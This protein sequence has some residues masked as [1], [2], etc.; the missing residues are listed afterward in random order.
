MRMTMVRRRKGKPVAKRTPARV[1]ALRRTAEARPDESQ[2]K[3]ARRGWWIIALFFGVLGA[4]AVMAPLNGA[5]IANSVIK[6]LGN[7][8]SIQH[9]DGGIVKQ[10][11]VKENDHVNAGDALIVLDDTQARAEFEVLSQQYLV[12]RATELRLLAELNRSSELVPSADIRARTNEPELEAIWNGQIQ[13]FS[14]QSGPW[15]SAG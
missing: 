7:R 1:V 15:S 12:T 6:V 14:N 5:V 8:K 3:D 13:Q 2:R 4:W 10:L 11:N 9:L